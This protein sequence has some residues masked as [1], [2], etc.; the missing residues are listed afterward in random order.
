MPKRE[1]PPMQRRAAAL[2]KSWATTHKDKRDDLVDQ[3]KQIME[4]HRGELEAEFGG[5]PDDEIVAL[6]DAAR[7]RGDA[8]F[9]AR[10]DVWFLN[11]PKRRI[12]G[13]IEPGA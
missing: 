6:V 8:D 10:A 9:V 11:K 4:D 5:L 3:A 12:S 13:I 2:S 1:Q 7:E